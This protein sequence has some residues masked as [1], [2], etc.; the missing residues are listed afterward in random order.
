M[1]RDFLIIE[2]HQSDLPV[3]RAHCTDLQDPVPERETP[4]FP[5]PRFLIDCKELALKVQH[6]EKLEECSQQS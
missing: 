1:R 3:L 2:R 5:E 4:R 6:K